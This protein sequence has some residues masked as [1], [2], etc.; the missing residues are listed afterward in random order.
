MSL[1]K[2]MFGAR[3][4]DNGVAIKMRDQLMQ[5]SLRRE[6]YGQGMIADTFA[7]RFEATTLHAFILFKRLRSCGPLGEAL[8]QEVF[9]LI[10][11]GFDD[12]VRE[13]GT[14][15]LKVG[16]KIKQL[17]RAF[18]GR[19]EAYD[20]AMASENAETALIDALA[21]NMNL[22]TASAERLAR[23]A[24]MAVKDFEQKPDASFMS[25]DIEWPQ[26]G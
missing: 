12:A 21:R 2:S 22:E 17:A 14:S 1:L 10:F 26:P 3:K 19:A 23:Y 18:Y 15:D 4:R 13:M 16:D 8:S 20:K 24:N 25:G 11:D 5:Q 6:F 9:D 7:G